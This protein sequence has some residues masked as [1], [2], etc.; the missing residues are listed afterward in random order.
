MSCL[1]L[2]D[3]HR[4]HNNVKAK[5]NGHPMDCPNVI[6]II[7]FSNAIVQYM[8]MVIKSGYA[9]VAVTAMFGAGED[10]RITDD[11][12]VLIV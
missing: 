6:I 2:V 7:L 1:D 10:A 5:P 12:I 9:S 4:S 3:N 8:T 11:A